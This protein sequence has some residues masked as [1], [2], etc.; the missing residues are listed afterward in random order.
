MTI[1]GIAAA[2]A[3]LGLAALVRRGAEPGGIQDAL[4][5]VFGNPD[6]GPVDFSTLERRA[7]PND[8]LACPP[9][10]CPAKADF[11]PPDYPVPADRLRAIVAAVA[12]AEAGTERIASDPAGEDRYLARSR[13][14]RFPDTIS[15][16]VFARGGGRST[17]A[18]YSRSQIGLG[19]FGVNRARLVRWL[20]GIADAVK[21]E[22]G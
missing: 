3:G 11:A 14:F 22:P 19:D 8:A 10:L 12:V 21:R 13:V 4:A 7:T 20:D 6:L 1:A 17:L 5:L 16:R 18:L 9:D 15:V 2:L